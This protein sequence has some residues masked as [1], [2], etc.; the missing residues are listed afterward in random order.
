MIVTQERT[1]WKDFLL[2]IF[3]KEKRTQSSSLATEK[4]WTRRPL[5]RYVLKN[6]SG[7]DEIFPVVNK[8]QRAKIASARIR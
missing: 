8:E 1:Q 3:L 6:L 4:V 5:Y 7:K 2:D